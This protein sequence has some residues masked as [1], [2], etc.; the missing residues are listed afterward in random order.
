M[1]TIG[2]MHNN[3]RLL[4]ENITNDVFDHTSMYEELGDESRTKIG[5]FLTP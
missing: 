3:V 4:F 1:L 2:L 5:V